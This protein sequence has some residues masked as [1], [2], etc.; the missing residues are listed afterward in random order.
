M[1]T[2]FDD[3]LRDRMFLNTR[4]IMVSIEL[5]SVFQNVVFLIFRYILIGILIDFDEQNLKIC[6]F[7]KNNNC[8]AKNPLQQTQTN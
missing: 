7:S 4:I 8:P 3:I 2:D 5:R 6:V 1:I